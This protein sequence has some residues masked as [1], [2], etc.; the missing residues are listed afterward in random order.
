MVTENGNTPF[1]YKIFQK[2]DG[3]NLVKFHNT[4]L[5]S[6]MECNLVDSEDQIAI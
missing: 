5:T 6:E 3:Y 2:V 4:Y 1:L